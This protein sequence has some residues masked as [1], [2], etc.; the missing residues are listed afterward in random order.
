M[1]INEANNHMFIHYLPDTGVG[2]PLPSRTRLTH[3]DDGDQ[4]IN[5][6]D[7]IAAESSDREDPP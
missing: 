2:Y 6:S 3:G 1:D 7:R 4:H 5:T